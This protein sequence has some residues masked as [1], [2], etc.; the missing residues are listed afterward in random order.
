MFEVGTVLNRGAE[1]ALRAPAVR[2]KFLQL[3]LSSF[4]RFAPDAV[5]QLCAR[6]GDDKLRAIG[7]LSMLSWVP[8]ELDIEIVDA[9]A[10]V[11]GKE[12]FHAF[13]LAYVAE[14]MPRPPL[15]A[16]ID[17]GAKMLGL[18]PQSFLRWWD[19]GWKAVYRECGKVKGFV[20][21]ENHGSIVYEK[22]PRACIGS[23]A[24]IAAIVSTAQVVFAWNGQHGTVRVAAHRPEDGYLELA[25]SWHAPS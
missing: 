21:D 8:I 6:V 20:Q 18:S 11:L 19:K 1:T 13:T 17:L 3:W 12:R 2:A 14:I 7:E 5:T 9:I 22:M 25:L 24:F 23:E 16:L 4:E 15:G 10:E